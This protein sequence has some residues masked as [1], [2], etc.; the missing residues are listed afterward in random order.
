MLALHFLSG[1]QNGRSPRDF[2]AEIIHAFF[3]CPIRD[4][5]AT[6]LSFSQ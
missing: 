3:V 2:D 4:T 5:C 6:H 1:H